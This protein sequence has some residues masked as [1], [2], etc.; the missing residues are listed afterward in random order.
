MTITGLPCCK[1][2]KKTFQYKK[3]YFTLMRNGSTNSCQTAMRSS[4]A[5]WQWEIMR[6]SGPC[7]WPA[8]IHGKPCRAL[9][10]HKWSRLHAESMRATVINVVI[11]PVSRLLSVTLDHLLRELLRYAL[12]RHQ[13]GSKEKL[14]RNK[15]PVKLWC[16]P[17]HLTWL[18][19]TLLLLK[20]HA[21]EVI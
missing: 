1:S 15:S 20:C 3:N 17:C 11:K 18:W 14:H 19:K 9:P 4:I 21:A 13:T 12:E 8:S 16:R 6:E 2:S 7:D 5:R 10:F